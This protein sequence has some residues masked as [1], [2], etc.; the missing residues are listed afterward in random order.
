MKDIAI[1]TRIY[2][3]NRISTLA[4]FEGDSAVRAQLAHLRRGISKKPG[5]QPELWEIT[6]LQ[7]PESMMSKDGDPTY[8]EWAVHTALTLFALHQQGK[9]IKSQNMHLDGRRL[10]LAVG[11]LV[12]PD[13]D[14]TRIKRRFDSAAT[15][16]SIE[17]ISYHLRG[18]IQ[19]MKDKEVKLDYA[20]LAEDLFWYQFPG[21]R[22]SVRLSWGRDFYRQL[23]MN[24]EKKNKNAKGDVGK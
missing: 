19:L 8:A 4:S 2:V 21:R 11:E 10:G 17:E 15:A 1:Q 16:N 3:R 18:L 24:T 7:I 14:D 6:L 22:D 20:S 12:G 13:G 9:D 23:Y 5:S